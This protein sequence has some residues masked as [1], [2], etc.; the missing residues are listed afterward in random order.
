MLDI[1]RERMQCVCVYV[2]FLCL[3]GLLLL[4]P[5]HPGRGLWGLAPWIHHTEPLR[6]S[7]SNTDTMFLLDGTEEFTYLWKCEQFKQ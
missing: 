7:T 4:S 6:G 3:P 2:F 5:P 1:G